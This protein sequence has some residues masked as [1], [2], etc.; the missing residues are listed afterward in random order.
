MADQR[1][2]VVLEAHALRSATATAVLLHGT[3][4]SARDLRRPFGA[5]IA[6]AILAVVLLVAVAA[7][8]LIGDAL[9]KRRLERERR[10]ALPP[11]AAITAASAATSADQLTTARTHA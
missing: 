6:G 4:R 5:L 1:S 7:A 2:R 11:T 3:R 10:N 8:T 9:E